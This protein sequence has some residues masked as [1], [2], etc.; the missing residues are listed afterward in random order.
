MQTKSLEEIISRLQSLAIDEEFD[1]IVAI[2]R[3]GLIPAALVQQRL[4]IDLE[5]LWLNIRDE[6]NNKL[7]DQPILIKPITFDAT[8]KR[9]L[10]V[11]DRNKT[12]TTLA[13]AQGLLKKAKVVKTLVVNGEADYSLYN[14]SCFK[15]PW[16][17]DSQ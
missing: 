10:L 2:A 16:R 1:L 7:Y 3:G 14:E 12:G 17:I 6:Q 11:D 15:M 9:I 5:T 13:F 4:G 8:D